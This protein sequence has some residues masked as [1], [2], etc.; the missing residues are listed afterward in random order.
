MS[1]A[2]EYQDP[3]ERTDHRY[4]MPSINQP[5]GLENLLILLLPQSRVLRRRVAPRPLF[6]DLQ[7]RLRD[8]VVVPRKDDEKGGG[9]GWEEDEAFFSKGVGVEEAAAE[10]LVANGV[11]GGLVVAVEG[12]KVEVGGCFVDSPV[13]G[14]AGEKGVHDDGGKGK[15]EA[16]VSTCVVDALFM[17]GVIVLENAQEQE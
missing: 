4:E 5:R 17:R 13:K 6:V 2:R 1:P 8:I 3:R 16:R 9:N 7:Q 14:I 11:K 10:G 12:R 15:V